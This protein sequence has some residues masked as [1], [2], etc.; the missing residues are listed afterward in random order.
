MTG[1]DKGNDRRGV[2]V[3]VDGSVNAANAARWA[4]RE[5]VTREVQLTVVHALHLHGRPPFAAEPTA[6][7]E[8]ER[9]QGQRLLAEVAGGLRSEFPTLEVNAELSE[10]SAARA[11]T[12]LSLEH[13][14]TVLG[15]RGHGGFTGMLLGSVSRKLAAHAHCPLVVVR[16]EQ[17][18]DVLDEVVLGVEPDQ[19]EPAIR[20]AFAAAQRYGATL[21]AVR[22]WQPLVSS[23]GPLG[24]YFA[25]VTDI[26]NH[27]RH[28]VEELLAPVHASFPSVKVEVSAGRGNPVPLLIETARDTRL[29]VVGARRNRGPLS[30]G[31]GYVVDGL[32]AHSVT[33]VAVVPMD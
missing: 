12:A 7:A 32:L 9:E 27:E 30:V 6:Y 17:S 19:A 13:A 28:E 22:C 5:A 14:L 25:D 15:T 33:P 3:G 4:A 1:N 11:L 20:Y 23:S 18:Q 24:S 10:E 2:V 8:H 21:H 26:R 31:S 16:S 29:L